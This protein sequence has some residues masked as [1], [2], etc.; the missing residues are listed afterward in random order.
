MRFPFYDCVSYQLSLCTK[1]AAFES[2][3]ES[4]DF[5][6]FFFKVQFWLQ[7]Q[8]RNDEARRGRQG[9][10]VKKTQAYFVPRSGSIHTA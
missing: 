2:G 4:V 7:R 1:P 5:H 3:L 6:D 9:W 10:M 8:V